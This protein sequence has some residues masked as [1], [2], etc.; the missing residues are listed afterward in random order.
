MITLEYIVAALVVI[1]IPGTGV[2]Y[3]VGVGL[4]H[5]RMTMLYAA[6]GCTLAI[7][8][9][10]LA[11]IFGLSALLN[12]STILFNILK[13]LGVIYLLYMAFNLFMD[14]GVLQFTSGEIG[15]KKVTVIKNGFLVNCFNPKLSIFFL[16]FIPQF[17]SKSDEAPL[18]SMF[19][20][21]CVFMLLTLLVFIVYGYFAN[22]LQLKATQSKGIIK[23]IQKCFA[24]IFG[25]L[26]YKMA[27][28]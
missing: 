13:Y 22:L 2:I 28:I 1:L 16:A 26:A 20:L 23:G 19:T 27:N 21:G 25:L 12:S 15:V 4:I 24:F 8:P 18:L 14:K 7:T 9:H 10:L 5:D 17:I 3:T 6:L 11:S